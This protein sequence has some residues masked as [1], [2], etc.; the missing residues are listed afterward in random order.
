MGEHALTPEER[1][2]AFTYDSS[3]DE[4]LHLL[5]ASLW[6]EQTAGDPLVTRPFRPYQRQHRR[7]RL[8]PSLVGQRARA[9]RNDVADIAGHFIIIVDRNLHV[10][11]EEYNS[12]DEA[13]RAISSGMETT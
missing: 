7:R 11:V 2:L 9:Y 6:D 4:A 13:D 1:P 12:R 5:V 3:R 8:A 10:T